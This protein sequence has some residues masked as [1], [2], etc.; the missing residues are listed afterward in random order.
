MRSLRWMVLAIVSACLL[1]GSIFAQ[2]SEKAK[3][4]FGVSVL[5]PTAKG[6]REWFAQWD[7]ERVVKSY[8]LDSADPFFV[9]ED[10]D[11][12]IKDGVASVK[13][14]LTRLKVVTPKTANGQYIGPLWTNVEMTVYVKR[15]KQAK[16]MDY[17]AFYLSARSGE[18]HNDYVPCEGT[19]YHATARFDGQCGFKKEL[20]HTGGYAGLKPEPTP[21]PWPTVPEGKWIGMK[22]VCRNLDDG[23]HVKLEMYLDVEEKNEWKLVSEFTDMGGWRGMKAGCDRPQDYIITEGCPAVYFRTD[24]VDVEV[25]KFSVREIAPLRRSRP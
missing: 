18:K 5:N 17:Q 6:G 15:G 23:K 24:Q 22:Y 4:R 12:R 21:R 14:G 19:S 2:S 8:S 20:W 9:N 13:A 25:K 16:Q 11:L 1:H 3:D 7:K 10:G